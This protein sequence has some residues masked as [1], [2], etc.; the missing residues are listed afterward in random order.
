MSDA[1]IPLVSLVGAGPGN[2]G[3][4]TLRAVE[5]LGQAD[6]VIFD[7][8][9]PHALLGHARAGARVVCVSELNAGHP[10]DRQPVLEAM[11]EGARAGQR[12]VRLKGGDPMIFGRGGEEADALRRAGISCEIIPGVTAAL[13]AAAF[14][15]IP[16]T[17]V[18]TPRRSRSSPATR[19]PEARNRS[20]GRPSPLPRHPGR[21][22]GR[23]AATG[24]CRSSSSSGQTPDAR[25]RRPVGD[26]RRPAHLTAN[27]RAAGSSP[28][29]HD[30][31]GISSSAG[32]RLRGARLV[33]RLPL[34]AAA[35]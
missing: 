18:P 12:V 8:L 17:I 33:E 14:A 7:K 26:A 2:P 25:R 5:L 3:L 28:R 10:G 34:L 29:R 27:S 4:L 23:V 31:A 15:G 16:L 6:L 30:A 35:S 19:I 24:S 9:V 11:I 13:G 22:H 1:S 21:L 20:T 32:R